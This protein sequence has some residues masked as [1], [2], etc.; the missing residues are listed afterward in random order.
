MNNRECIDIYKL[1]KINLSGF[2]A[3]IINVIK[4]KILFCYNWQGSH[5]IFTTFKYKLR[6]GF[7][8]GMI[9][10]VECPQIVKPVTYHR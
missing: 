4:S 10:M 9:F 5:I 6:G 3:V 7:L 8:L 1:T 2:I